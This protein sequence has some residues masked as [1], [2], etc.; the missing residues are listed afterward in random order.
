M[1][2]TVHFVELLNRS[3]LV[4]VGVVPVD[5]GHVTGPRCLSVCLS[6]CL[7]LQLYAVTCFLLIIVSD[8]SMDTV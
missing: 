3:L 5:S 7:R 1:A 6:V 2:H 8:K 4:R